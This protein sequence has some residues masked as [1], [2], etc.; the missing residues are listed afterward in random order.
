MAAK[1][2]T[3]SLWETIVEWGASLL[4]SSA[5]VPRHKRPERAD[6]TIHRVRQVHMSSCGIAVAAMFA[7]QRHHVVKRF[8]FPQPKRDYGTYYKDVWRALTH[9]GVE[10]TERKRKFVSWQDIPSTAL[11]RIRWKDMPAARANHWVV[12]QKL[13]KGFR[14]IDPGS[15]G[16]TLA[17]IN[18][19]DCEGLDYSLVTHRTREEGPLRITTPPA[20]TKDTK[21][22]SAPKRRRRKRRVRKSA[23]A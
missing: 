2:K 23:R 20:S 8:M 1:R 15:W 17:D 10:H 21:E 19:D 16:E 7:R 3:S 14:V 6:A 11:V 13:P 9:F 4:D 22:T 12:Y 18:L 5:N